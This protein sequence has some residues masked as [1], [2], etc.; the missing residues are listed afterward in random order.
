MK[1]NLRLNVLSKNLLVALDKISKDEKLIKLLGNNS[2]NPLEN[3]TECKDILLENLFIEPFNMEVPQEQKT[4]LRIFF[5]EG[6]FESSNTLSTSV[7]YFQI[8]IHK[9]LSRIIIDNEKTLREF[10]IMDTIINLFSKEVIKGIGNINFQG[11]QYAFID[12]DYHMYTLMGEVF[13]GQ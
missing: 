11:Y 2:K 9:N 8:I 12:K 5:P 3:N 6:T 7:I 10:E 1:N 13:N 4:E